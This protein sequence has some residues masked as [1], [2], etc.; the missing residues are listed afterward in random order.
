MYHSRGHKPPAIDTVEVT[1]GGR[2]EVRPGSRE[3]GTDNYVVAIGLGTP[4]REMTVVMDTG[5]AITWVQCSPC[6]STKCHP[7]RDDIFDPAMSSTYQTFDCHSS[8][9]KRLP[10]PNCS[11]DDGSC[12]YKTTYMDTSYSSGQFVS[13]RLTLDPGGTIENFLFGC[14]HDQN[15][16]FF[17]QASGLLGLG[18]PSSGPSLLDQ[19]A[20][21]SLGPSFA[22]C[23]PREDSTGYLEFGAGAAD[24]GSSF[25]TLTSKGGGY[26]VDLLAL[27][28]NGVEGLPI[29]EKMMVDT[30]TVLSQLPAE[31][32][33]EI[34][35]LVE[36]AAG[37]A[38][39]T[40]P[41]QDYF[42][43]CYEIAADGTK[44][45]L[46]INV[47]LKLG[48][49]ARIVLD[50]ASVFYRNVS[51]NSKCL[52]FVSKGDTEDSAVL[53]NIVQRAYRWSFDLD[54][55]RIAITPNA[56]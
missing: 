9:C 40:A 35:A 22:Y 5:S 51:S 52:A 31:L 43:D 47:A 6:T 20:G 42:R 55:G 26:Y 53:G 39:V 54:N 4:P 44:E 49:G 46:P 2:E 38:L 1:D 3:F 25:A 56:C 7:Q 30:G 33:E 11:P 14:G 37:G 13:D 12:S 48:G 45:L 21:T 32:Y 8:Q 17:G 41:Q 36:K 27:E 16:L 23:L 19:A 24:E 50:D 29:S 15:S 28:V 34:K 18:P 10:S